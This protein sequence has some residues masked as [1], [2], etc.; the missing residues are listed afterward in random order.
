RDAGGRLDVAVGEGLATLDFEVAN[1]K[2]VGRG[3]EDLCAPV[4]VAVDRLDAATHGWG[5]E[6]GGVA[7]AKDGSSVVFGEGLSVAGAHSDAGVGDAAGQHDDQIA[8]DGIDLLFDAAL[9]AGADRNHGNHG[10]D[11]DDDAE[12]G[13]GGAHL[14]DAQSAEGDGNAGRDF[15]G[16]HQKPSFFPLDWAGVGGEAFFTARPVISVWPSVRFPPV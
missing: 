16:M 5:G 3:A 7:F 1:W 4:V 9:R 14:I 13:E 12:H 10:G 6:R 15:A 8:A 11:T 2:V